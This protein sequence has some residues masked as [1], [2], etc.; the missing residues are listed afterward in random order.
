MHPAPTRSRCICATPATRAPGQLGH[1]KGYRY[2]HDFPG[3]AVDQE[4]RPATFLG[5]RYYE[6]SGQGR[7]TPRAPGTGKRDDPQPDGQDG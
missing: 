7:D 4:Y 5:H 6:P 1:G 2:P 3:H